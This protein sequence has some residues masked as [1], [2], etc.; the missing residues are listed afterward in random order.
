MQ[1]G[2]YIVS[3]VLGSTLAS[4][5]LTLIM[6]ITSDA[7]FGTTPAG[8]TIQSFVVEIIL[9]FILMFIISGACG[10]D[11]AVKMQGGI[12]V[13]MTIILNVFVGGPISGASMNP[14]RTLGPAIVLRKFTAIWVYICGPIIGAIT[15]AFVYKLL[16]PTDK[17]FSDIVKGR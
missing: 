8:S 6:N 11:R 7:F 5:T 17:S 10:D 3:Q 9:T 16:T 1:V 15:G 12:V 2:L 4:V 14:A 13:G